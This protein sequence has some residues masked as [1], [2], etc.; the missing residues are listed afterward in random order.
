MPVV[1]NWIERTIFLSLNQGP[2][3][4]LDIWNAVAFRAVLAA[5]RLDVFEALASG[6]M[7]VVELAQCLN[8]DARGVQRLI[9]ALEPLGYVKRQG[10]AS[11]ERGRAAA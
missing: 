5:V 3:P 9:D 8:A 4:V 2:G 6:P 1:P 10:G 7:N 11:V